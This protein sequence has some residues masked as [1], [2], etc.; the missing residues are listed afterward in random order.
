[1]AYSGKVADHF[2]NPRNVG[3]FDASDPRVGTGM[4]GTPAQGDVIRLQ[5]RVGE[6]GIIEEARF[7]TYGCGAAIAA[8]SL[9]T[10]WL[11]GKTLDDAV[12]IDN[13]AIARELQLD[14]VKLYCALL[15]EDAIAAAVRNYRDKH[16][17]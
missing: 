15:A 10:E 17:R 12:A 13:A 16:R 1:M 6:S 3:A 11:R 8:S 14:S 5:I 4:I 2:E 9:V 7:K